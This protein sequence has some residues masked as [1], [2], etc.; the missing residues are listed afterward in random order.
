MVTDSG[1]STV[2][3]LG[4]PVVATAAALGAEVLGRGVAMVSWVCAAVVA[5]WALLLALGIGLA[6]FP[7]AI[8]LFAAAAAES[9]SKRI[10]QER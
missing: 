8:V 4:V 9:G 6:F 7:T 5:V 3:L 10:S 2:Y 1:S